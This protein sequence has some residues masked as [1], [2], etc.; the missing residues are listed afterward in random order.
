MIDIKQIV[1]EVNKLEITEQLNISLM[2][3]CD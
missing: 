3:Q 2:Y 1:N